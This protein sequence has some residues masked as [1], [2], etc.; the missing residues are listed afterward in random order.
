MNSQGEKGSLMNRMM[1]RSNNYTSG[2]FMGIGIGSGLGLLYITVLSNQWEQLLNKIQERQTPD[3]IDLING[4][5]EL[6]SSLLS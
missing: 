1:N 6:L 4:L 3:A 2:L 5:I